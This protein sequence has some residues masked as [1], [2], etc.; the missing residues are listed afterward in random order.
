MQ[1]PNDDPGAPRRLR[2]LL[3]D[4]DALVGA[5]FS[6]ML[7]PFKVT[8]A[9]SAAGALARIQ[10]GG[11]FDAILCDLFMPGMNGMQFHDEVAKISP[12]LARA[13]IYVSG[14]TSAPEAA[15]FFTRTSKTCLPKPIERE[16]LMSAVLAAA[17]EMR[18]LGDGPAT[19]LAG[20]ARGA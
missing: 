4:D 18:R 16:Q 10:V 15:A 8:F 20:T 3:V 6:R 19:P 9:Q 1:P 5:A 11:R 12:G 13:I 7:S 2:I 14:N 17:D